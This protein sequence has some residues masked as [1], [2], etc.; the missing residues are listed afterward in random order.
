MSNNR[1][2]LVRVSY[3]LPISAEDEEQALLQ[4]PRTAHTDAIDNDISLEIERE[5]VP[6]D[7]LTSLGAEWGEVIPYDVD[8]SDDY[9][10]IEERLKEQEADLPGVVGTVLPV[11]STA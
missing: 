9:R 8:D 10:T 4:I 6:E 3:V 5:I 11:E 1:V 2:F 7:M